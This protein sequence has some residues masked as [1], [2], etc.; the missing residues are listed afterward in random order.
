VIIIYQDKPDNWQ[1]DAPAQE[2]RNYGAKLRVL[3]IAGCP[4][5]GEAGFGETQACLRPVA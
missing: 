4:I 1:Y 5:E 2:L 3:D